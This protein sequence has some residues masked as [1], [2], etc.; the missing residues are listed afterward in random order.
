MSPPLV[1][2]WVH[3]FAIFVDD[4][5]LS[6][7]TSLT[8]PCASFL[9]GFDPFQR[10]RE[11]G[12]VRSKM[13]PQTVGQRFPEEASSL[14]LVSSYFFS[15]SRQCINPWKVTVIC[16]S[17]FPS[18]TF[19]GKLSLSKYE[20]ALPSQIY[21]LLHVIWKDLKEISYHFI[22]LVTLRQQGEVLVVAK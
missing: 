5:D 19:W 18:G 7:S 1:A 12:W 21:W 11:E 16:H 4:T 22:I 14:S 17:V 15:I 20:E 10:D 6:K 2:N 3:F 9:Y 8:F 13:G